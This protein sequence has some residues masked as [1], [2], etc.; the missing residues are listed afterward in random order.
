MDQLFAV[1]PP[2]MNDP[3]LANQWALYNT[4]LADQFSGIPGGCSI[5]GS[6]IKALN[7]WDV[8]TGTGIKIA[9]IDQGV[10]LT[11]EDLTANLIT[12][13][14]VTYYPFP[15]LL[16]PTGGASS[17][18]HGTWCAGLAAAKGNNAL[19]ISGVAFNAS[20]IPIRAFFGGTL[21]TEWGAAGIDAAVAKN[22]DVISCT[23]GGSVPNWLT[24]TAI[25]NAVTTG[26]GGKGCLVFFAAGNSNENN[27]KYPASNPEVIAVGATSPT[28]ARQ[29]PTNCT[30]SLWGSDYGPGIDVMAPGMQLI[31]TNTSS[32]SS[33]YNAFI[34]TSASC[35]VAAGVGALILSVNSALTLAQARRILEISC[36]KVGGVTYTDNPVD[37][38]NGSWHEEMGYG[39]VNAF[40]AVQRATL[41]TY[42]LTLG[43]E[44]PLF[45]TCDASNI[46]LYLNVTNNGSATVTS[47][48]VTVSVNGTPAPGMPIT[49]TPTGFVTKDNIA[50]TTITIS[51]P[52]GSHTVAIQI[53]PATI[54]GG[55]TDGYIGDNVRT[56]TYN[57][58]G[59]A[60]P[61]FT[62]TFESNSFNTNYWEI[63]N[64]FNDVIT[65]ETA[66]VSGK[67]GS[68]AA[69]V[70][71][72]AYDVNAAREKMIS[73]NFNLSAVSSATLGFTYAY[74]YVNLGLDPSYNNYYDSLRVYASK[75]CGNNWTVVYA[76][77]ENG[78]NTFSTTSDGETFFVPATASDWC[79]SGVSGIP[80]VQID[81]AA[82]GFVGVGSDNVTFRFEVANHWGNCLYVDDIQLISG[83]KAVMTGGGNRCAGSTAYPSVAVGFMGGGAS[84][85]FT[86]NDGTNHTIT[87]TDNP[88]YITP[89]GPAAFAM[90]SMTGGAVSGSATVADITA[91]D[92]P[93]IT[94]NVDA[95]CKTATPISLAATTS[96]A[97]ATVGLNGTSQIVAT[98]TTDATGTMLTLEAWIYPTQLTGRQQIFWQKNAA[99]NIQWDA[100][101][102]DS[103]Q[104]GLSVYS[105]GVYYHVVNNV[106]I[107]I[108]PNEWN[109]VMFCYTT[110]PVTYPSFFEERNMM[111]FINGNQCGVRT[112]GS[113]LPL[114]AAGGGSAAAYIGSNNGTANFFKGYIDEARI[115]NKT[116]DWFTEVDEL[117]HS[118]YPA[119]K[120][121]LVRR[122]SF[123]ETSG[124][125]V[126]DAV[127][128]NTTGSTNGTR[129]AGSTAPLTPTYAWTKPADIVYNPDDLNVTVVNTG[130]P[131]E[132]RF[133]STNSQTGCVAEKVV[134]IINIT[135]G[136][137]VVA[138]VNQTRT[139]D[140]E[141][142]ITAG[143][144][145]GWTHYYDASSASA[146][147]ILLSVKKEGSDI[148]T[149]ANG[150]VVM[151]ATT[152]Q[153]ASGVA[154][155]ITAPTAPYVGNPGG[156]YVMNRYWK[157]AGA[158]QP[159]AAIPVRSYY[160]DSDIS[161]VLTTVP[162]LSG[163]AQMHFY[164]INSAA[165]PNPA[166]GHAGVM[167]SQIVQYSYSA[168]TPTGMGT[169][170]QAIF[171]GSPTNKYA[172]H[173]ITH[174]SG[175]GGGGGVGGVGFP[176]EWLGLQ[177]HYETQ[178]ISHATDNELLKPHVVLDWQTASEQNTAHFEIE[179]ASAP[180][181]GAQ[182]TWSGIGQ[183][184][185]AG[186]S[187][188][189]RSYT[190]TD[191]QLPYW[192]MN[193]V[194]AGTQF[195]PLASSVYYRIKSVD[196]DGKTD[197]SNVAEVGL[198][199]PSE[200]IVKVANPVNKANA[201]VTLMV[202]YTQKVNVALIASDGR[203]VVQLLRQVA[204]PGTYE[205]QLPVNELA[206]GMYLLQVSGDKLAATRKLIIE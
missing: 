191:E 36:D 1:P 103:T 146:R 58:V 196:F 141:C 149:I 52:V 79:S 47:F 22:A 55:N 162:S 138:A 70:N 7:A 82:A 59:S 112:F 204:A 11:H 129:V 46:Y 121:N 39:R 97:G 163:I 8:S 42:D 158:T 192:G 205:M 157:V 99:G 67:S 100:F 118:V 176:V 152:P 92:A 76:G 130:T 109:H 38:P 78:S 21:L 161:D 117:I 181:T 156:W 74:R 87:T 2:A 173:F 77:G 133:V 184:Q 104:M 41:P 202:P 132:M 113:A 102:N 24:N 188:E 134:P 139:A 171:E 80:C 137:S 71:C 90:V 62:E 91:D 68:Y 88:Y 135:S 116:F 145:V 85:T 150:L 73:R 125:V 151:A 167:G 3:L 180:E 53:V 142:T 155:P 164:K 98:P 81:L 148:G 72:S 30:A 194:A 186:T 198:P 107:T 9:V 54:N 120:A 20:I 140:A 44:A 131:S 40:T 94:M 63:Q 154:T 166:N 43:V 201:I 69:R 93:S 27:V 101:I 144:D 106:G 16:G 56:V 153:Y 26:R 33:Y 123:N 29:N 45:N 12:G 28:D 57:V 60:L 126:K 199:S 197:Y 95:A 5:A 115:W 170:S 65:W 147:E 175:G 193:S 119:G 4:G 96:M 34:G 169:F 159:L 187:N 18:S 114:G 66:L 136:T 23:W 168:S 124:T 172:E 31:T 160:T 111:L 19:G 10:R 128:G 179:R 37:Q 182:L 6:D 206:S 50:L 64:A 84:R 174:F 127:T 178:D 51:A 49:F 89:T 61:P 183:V 35:P 143:T 195:A 189:V 185:A 122:F 25:H 13:E 165:D 108:T 32:N 48:Q 110:A 86:Y 15:T 14:S 105:N 177:A 83:G 17:G 190:F 200:I 75:D 203:T